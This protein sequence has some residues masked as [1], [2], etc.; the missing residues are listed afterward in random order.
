MMLKH[1][2]PKDF[3]KK[4][5]ENSSEKNKNT[6]VTREKVKKTLQPHTLKRYTRMLAM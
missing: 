1:K 6:L 3:F 4:A 5:P 2:S